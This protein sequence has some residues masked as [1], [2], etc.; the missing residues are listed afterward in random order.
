MKCVWCVAWS[1]FFATPDSPIKPHP[2]H[3]QAPT[4]LQSDMDTLHPVQK[5]LHDPTTSTTKPDLFPE[6]TRPLRP[7]IN[8]DTEGPARSTPKEKQKQK[9]MVLPFEKVH[10]L[11]KL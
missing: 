7:Q 10:K 6:L 8:E 4:T 9:I 3:A 5:S 1:Y 2:N 11:I